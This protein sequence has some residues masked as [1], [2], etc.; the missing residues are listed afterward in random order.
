MIR[1]YLIYMQGIALQTSS[2]DIQP[3][4]KPIKERDTQHPFGRKLNEV[5]REKGMAGDYAALAKIFNVKTPSIY[6]W[7]DHGRMSK[8]RYATL[9]T[10]SG[11]SLEWWFGQ[12][13]MGSQQADDNPA[14][15]V[16]LRLEQPCTVVRKK[17]WPFALVSPS[18]LGG[19]DADEIRRV[20]EFAMILLATKKTPKQQNGW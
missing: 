2:V 8:K 18:D 6:D 5:M 1:H 3:M 7:L 16:L 9:Q 19:L 15:R 10:W 20:E 17:D 4:A 14:T 13:H 11:R 12:E